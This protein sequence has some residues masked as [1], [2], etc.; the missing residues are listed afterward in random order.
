MENKDCLTEKER[1]WIDKLNRYAEKVEQI[2]KAQC[3]ETDKEVAESIA[4]IIKKDGNQKSTIKFE[5]NNNEQDLS[6]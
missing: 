5:V 6:M 4:K 1:K 3:Y 2:N